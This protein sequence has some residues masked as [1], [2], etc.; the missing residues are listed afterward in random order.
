MMLVDRDAAA[1]Q[2][3]IGIEPAAPERIREN[4]FV[5][6]AVGTIVGVGLEKPPEFWFHS[7]KMKVI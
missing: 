3:R 2:A 7:E 1:D 5:V 4:H 6:A